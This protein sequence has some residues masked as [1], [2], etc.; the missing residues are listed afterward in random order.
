[1]FKVNDYVVYKSMGVYKIADITVDRDINNNETEYYV[2]QQAFKDNLT[3]KI[4]VNNQ[5]VLMRRVIAKDDVLSLIASI[6]E[7]EIVWIDNNRERSESFKEALN[8]GESEEWLKLI[9][10]IYLEKQEKSDHGKK[11][12]KSDEEIMKLAEKNLNEE[13]AIALN[14][15]P[16]EVPDFIREHMPELM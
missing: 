16:E 9:R 13:F 14:I 5:K 15:T 8:S 3:I 1:M 4:P 12:W 11:L 6:P 7:T 10:T 2:L